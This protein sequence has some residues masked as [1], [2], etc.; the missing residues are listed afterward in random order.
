MAI[1]Y[2]NIGSNLGDKKKNLEN[3][4]EYIGKTFGYC[5]ISNIVESEPWGFDS[6]NSF[7]NIGVAFKSDS[8]PEDILRQLQSIEKRL[9]GI[10][11]RDSRGNYQ[12]REVDIDI[13]A[14]DDI[15]YRSENLV[16]PHPH[17][18]EREFFLNPLKE[19]APEWK[20]PASNCCQ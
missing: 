2:A 13:M 8:H 11:H 3:A 15:I 6:T 18:F 20:N 10:S 12:D 14:I 16:V 1:V 4:I 19:L 9:S 5:C 7:Y 17:L